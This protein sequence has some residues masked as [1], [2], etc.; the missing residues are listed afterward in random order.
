[1]ATDT[2]IYSTYIQFSNFKTY[3]HSQYLLTQILTEASWSTLAFDYCVKNPDYYAGVIILF[4]FMHFIFVTV[5]G[6]LLKGIFW[7]IYF[8]VGDSI[9]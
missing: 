4:I 1:M 5:I 9:D 8:T 6:T 3:I 7:E 2:S